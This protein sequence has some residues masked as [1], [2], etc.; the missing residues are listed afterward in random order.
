[1]KILEVISMRKY[2]G[3]I[4]SSQQSEMRVYMKLV[5]TVVLE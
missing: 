5:M 2:A 3:K 4:S 1:M